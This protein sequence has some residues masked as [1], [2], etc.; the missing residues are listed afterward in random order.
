[1][2][3]KQ[4]LIQR[5]ITV[6]CNPFVTQGYNK[7]HQLLAKLL[8]LMVPPHGGWFPRQASV[9]TPTS[10]ITVAYLW[11]PQ[12]V[13]GTFGGLC[14]GL[15]RIGSHRRQMTPPVPWLI[16]GLQQRGLKGRLLLLLLFFLWPQM[17]Y[18]T[19]HLGTYEILYRVFL[20]WYGIPCA[21]CFAISE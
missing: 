10:T 4:D 19:C 5:Q 1:M 21:I 7:S 20:I 18:S 6:F 3:T 13:Q 8:I 11:A 16:L 9:N 2:S 15:W 12:A 17:A 14:G